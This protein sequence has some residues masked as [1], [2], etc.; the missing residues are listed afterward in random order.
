MLQVLERVGESAELEQDRADSA[1]GL[2]H[3]ER[4]A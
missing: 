1:M 3:E 2:E 4:I